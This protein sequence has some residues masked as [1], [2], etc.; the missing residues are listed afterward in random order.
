M[1]SAA[2]DRPLPPAR[3]SDAPAE[4]SDNTIGAASDL[5]DNDTPVV[6]L[7]LER[8]VIALRRKR[9]GLAIRPRHEPT[10]G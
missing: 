6:Y 9:D 2:S 4:A 7:Q 5:P 3:S 1:A 10:I 8:H